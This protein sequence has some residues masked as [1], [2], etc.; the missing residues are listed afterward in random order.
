MTAEGDAEDVY[1]Y[2]FDH[3]QHPTVEFQKRLDMLPSR[4]GNMM[5]LPQ[6]LVSNLK[7]LLILE[8]NTIEQGYEGLILRDPQARY[9]FGRST[10][11]EG[12][13]LKLKRFT[14]SEALVTGFE[15]LRHNTN[16]AAIDN[17]GYTKRS[18]HAENQ[19]PMGTLGALVCK[20][21]GH[22]VR[23]GTGFT[24]NERRYIWENRNVFLGQLVKFKFF[25]IGM[26][27]APRHPV[28][29]GWRTLTDV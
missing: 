26:K 18:S 27:D 10:Q 28:F 17:R 22:Q 29:L 13:M 19:V 8:E 1:Y 9:K 25:R 14:D 4:L 23:I 20:W 11:K 16:E 7:E 2:V 15:E 12:I 6:I 5:I 24:Q 3:T 21:E